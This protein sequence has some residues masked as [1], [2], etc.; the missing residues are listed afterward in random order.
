MSKHGELLRQLNALLRLT[1]TEIMVAETRRGQARTPAVQRE[2]AENAD[3]ARQRSELLGDAIR[4]LGGVPDVLGV[5]AGRMA[6][7]AKATAEQGQDLV[8]ALFGTSHWSTS[9]WTAPGWRR[10]SPTSST[11]AQSDRHS[12]VSRR[13]TR[14][15]ST[16]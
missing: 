10:C 12:C 13:L 9:S 15:R 11:R 1:Q 5:T 8:D 14:R 4:T 6:A 2:L 3:K 16:G 7:T